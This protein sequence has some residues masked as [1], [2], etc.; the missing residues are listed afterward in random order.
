[1]KDKT[2]VM[3]IEDVIRLLELLTLFDNEDDLQKIQGVIK[4]MITSIRKQANEQTK[5]V[6]I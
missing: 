4:D 1:M 3:N 2:P 6:Q 5:G